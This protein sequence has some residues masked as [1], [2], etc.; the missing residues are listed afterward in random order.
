[1]LIIVHL[2]HYSETTASL[3]NLPSFFLLCL[4]TLPLL[5]I[6]KANRYY[7]KG[8]SLEITSFS[9]NRISLG[10]LILL[11]FSF[12]ICLLKK[13]FF[14]LRRL[15]T[16]HGTQ[17]YNP[18]IKSLGPGTPSFLIYRVV[19]LSRWEQF[20]FLLFCFFENSFHMKVTWSFYL[21]SH[22]IINTPDLHHSVNKEGGG[23]WPK[24]LDLRVVSLS[25]MLC[26]EPS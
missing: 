11:Y 13:F 10:P 25:P 4:L 21:D 20:S 15:H 17:S 1:M 18:E 16:Q 19:H 3:P 9:W 5:P 23:A 14:F 26:V 12:L 2:S 24:T 22:E 7:L 6:T 8:E